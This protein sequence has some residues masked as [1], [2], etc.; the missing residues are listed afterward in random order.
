MKYKVSNR[1][2]PLPDR[3]QLNEQC[4]RALDEGEPSMT[5][6]DIYNSYT[7][8][9]GLHGLEYKD[10]GNYHD[11]SEAKKEIEQGQFFTSDKLAAWVM[12]CL[13][14][15]RREIIADLTCGKGTFFNHAPIAD[16]VYGCEIE[17]NSFSI[18]SYL[19]PKAHIR[20]GDMRTYQPEKRF[21]LVIGNPPYNIDWKFNGKRASSQAAYILKAAELLYPAGLLAVIVPESFL[22][23]STPKV[24]S[25]RIFEQFNHVVQLSLDPNAFAWLGVRNFPTKLLILQRKAVALS[26]VP[27]S[28]ELPLCEDSWEVFKTYVE[29]VK[30]K[31]NECAPKI[32]IQINREET[33]KATKRKMFD[34]PLYQ[35]KSHP[36]TK[37]YYA[38][39]AALVEQY[40]T[41]KCPDDMKHDEWER[42]RLHSEPILKQ[43]KKILS[44][45]NRREINKIELVKGK[46]R[47]YYK[48]YSKKLEDAAKKR[49]DK[50]DMQEINRLIPFGNDQHIKECGQY[51]KFIAKKQAAY[52]NQTTPYADM[53]EN[54]GIRE[55]LKKWELA[56]FDENFREKIIKLNEKQLYDTNLALQKRYSYLQWS[57]GAGKTVSGTA[58]GMYRLAMRQVDYVF[59]VSTAISIEG[60]WAPFLKE[61][62]IPHQTIRHHREL[63]RIL[64][65]DFVLITLGRIK[66]Y[67]RAI[68]RMAK[69]ASNKLF[70]IYDEAQNSSAL[71]ENDE[72]A[73]LTKAM[74]A[75]FR[76]AKYKLLMSGTSINNNVVEAYP[77]LYLLYNASCNMLS[78][79]RTLYYYNEG[80]DYYNEGSNG[81][82]GQPYPPYMAGKNLFRMSHLPE[83]LTVFGVVKRTPDIFNAEVL[84]EII[85]YTMI[86]RT[87][88][89]VTGK[90]LE[91]REEIRAVMTAE[92][93]KLYGVALKEFSRLEYLYFHSTNMSERKKAQARI[94]AQIKIMLRICTC[95]GVFPEY[96]GDGMTGKM[97]AIFDR[98]KLIPDKRVAIGVRH[99]SFVKEYARMVRKHFPERPVVTIIGSELDA[100]ARRGVVNGSF[101]DLDNAILISTQQSLCESIS[102]DFVD[103]CFIPEYHWN[104]SRMAQYYFR[105][106]RYTSDRIKR[107]YYVN[108][109]ESIETNLI[110]LLVSKER[111]LRFLKGQDISFEDLFA[112]MGFDLSEHQGYVQKQYDKDGRPEL[113][114]CERNRIAA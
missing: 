102:I 110:F 69:L 71:E 24:E 75:C 77:Q 112:E 39:S 53:R 98:I 63:R 26:E 5:K 95:A 74:F 61:H 2:I 33:A 11:F 100:K 104:N 51:T 55:W 109:P 21:D 14:P 13:R 10:Y 111:M 106:I 54:S 87:F 3:K 91:R 82:Y 12:G 64:P 7:G 84:R 9:G 20:L 79:A 43:L 88:Q 41:Q 103:Y 93:M 99:N 83:K 101:A 18:A 28:P 108:Y 94:I 29:P 22:G 73:R 38:E 49:N 52:R 58:Q 76:H 27:Y 56:R 23:D 89:E 68:Q 78:M 105:F 80:D 4:L 48:A 107:I 66:N 97:K 67:K 81:H 47:I 60:T 62:K 96:T 85:S 70:L 114:W 17:P 45:Q 90:D 65:G 46:K 35:I 25:R 44:E 1:K 57:Q 59:V 6:E 30:R 113:A 37:K 86:T 31:K 16:N 34:L 92:E 8:I 50:M 19:F 36:C 42:T 72:E 32:Q 15:E 40:F